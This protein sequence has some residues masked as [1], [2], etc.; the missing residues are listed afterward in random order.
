[1]ARL[2]HTPQPAT[3]FRTSCFSAYVNILISIEFHPVLCHYLMCKKYTTFPLV[4]LHEFIFL[5]HDY[6]VCFD[7]KFFCLI[8][9]LR[10]KDYLPYSIFNIIQWMCIFIVLPSRSMRMD[11]VMHMFSNLLHQLDDE[12]V[13]RVSLLYTVKQGYAIPIIQ[14]H[15]MHICILVGMFFKDTS[16]RSLLL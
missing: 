8:T 3:M 1:M 5:V 9:D 13:M 10:F 7:R 12:D 2:Q 14:T 6:Q 15:K 16:F 11:D 4:D